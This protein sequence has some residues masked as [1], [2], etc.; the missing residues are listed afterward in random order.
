MKFSVLCLTYNHAPFIAQCIE[1]VLKQ[2][3]SDWELV[4]L[5]DGSNDQTR[6]VV[7]QYLVDKRIKYYYQRNQGS[8]N[9]AINYNKLLSLATGEVITIL[10]GDDYC[11]PELLASHYESFQDPEVVLSFCQV[12]VEEKGYSWTSPKIPTNPEDLA[13]LNNIPLGKAYNLLLKQCYIPAQGTSV[14]MQTMHQIGGFLSVP[15]LQTVDYPT[16]LRIATVGSFHFIPKPL[17]T[18]RRHASQLTR[19]QIVPLTK[20]MIPVLLNTLNSLPIQIASNVNILPSELQ[21][22]WEKMLTIILI[23]GGRY[24][25]MVRDWKTARQY[26][27][28]SCKKWPALLPVWRIKTLLGVLMSY[29]HLNLEWLAPFGSA[30]SK[31]KSKFGSEHR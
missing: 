20:I 6:E 10:E 13:V 28:E 8:I 29:L 2:T 21:H 18:W 4:I 9:L 17:T 26:Y 11:T 7:K 25:L 14:R 15:G 31:N 5:D 19:Q 1:S 22:Y 12:Q 27:R 23:R 3:Y 24:K 16:W 30:S